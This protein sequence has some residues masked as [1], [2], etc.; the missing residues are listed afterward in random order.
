MTTFY[1]KV[2]EAKQ[3]ADGL[4]FCMSTE[5]ARYYLNGVYIHNQQGRLYAVA[6][7][8][9]RLGRLW[10]TPYG[11]D[12]ATESP[13]KENFGYILPDDAVYWLGK[14]KLP[15]R[16]DIELVKFAIADGEVALT[17]L[18]D[19]QSVVF[20]LVDGSYPDYERVIPSKRGATT[21]GFNGLYLADIGK[22]SRKLTDT[23]TPTVKLHIDNPDSAC[24][25]TCDHERVLYV[26]M[27]CR[28]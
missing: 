11:E 16:S 1:L 19:D 18:P 8:G 9:R 27:P 20:P 17:L 5:R 24:V 22:A 26:Q 4:A 25:V 21:V 3:I 6:T 28:V 10:L 2:K 12:G 13:L 23:Y 14:L 7:D 15:K